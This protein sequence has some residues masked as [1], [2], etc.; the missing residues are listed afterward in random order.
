MVAAVHAIRHLRTGDPCTTRAP[1][2]RS[3]SR[4]SSASPCW[5]PARSGPRPS[6]G[7]WWV[8]DE[9]TLVSFLI[10]FLLYAPT[11][12]CATRSRTAS[13]RPATRRCSR[14]PPA[15]SCRSTSSP[16]AWPS[17]SSTR[18]TF[19]T[20]EGGLPGEMWLTFLVCLAGMALLWVTLVRFELA[21]KSSRGA[22][23]APAPRARRRGA[24]A[25]ARLADRARSVPREAAVT[26]VADA[27][28]AARRGGQVRRRRRTSSSSPCSWSTSRSWPPSCARIERELGEL[29]E[30]AE[31]ARAAPMAELLAL[32]VSHKTAPLELRER[33]ALTEGRAAGLLGELVERRGVHE[34]A[35]ISTCN[36]TELYL[37]AAD[38]GRRRVAGARRCSRARPTSARP[39]WSATSTRCAA[40]RPPRTSSGSPRGSTR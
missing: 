21:A 6:W 28:A 12:R 34:A 39:S 27:R 11:T 25:A 38:G 8:W 23:L 29:A 13:A 7:K 18:A 32:G 36:R 10:V 16:C 5:S 35:A 33:I 3:T 14:S 37:V 4:S 2:S 22:D 15:P 17:R 30:L 40:P 19:A 9:P 20:A 24:R 31:E 26:R 1:T